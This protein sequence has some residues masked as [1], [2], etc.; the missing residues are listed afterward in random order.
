M[1]PEAGVSLVGAAH[2][3]F[4]TGDA[5]DSDCQ[6]FTEVCPVSLPGREPS[7]AVFAAAHTLRG[8]ERQHA[9]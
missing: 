5:S 3:R 6:Q 1:A 7:R 2:A 8:F 9:P 4:A